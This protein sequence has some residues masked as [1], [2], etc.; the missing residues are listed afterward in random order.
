M[1]T[2]EQL[3]SNASLLDLISGLAAM[4]ESVSSGLNVLVTGIQLDSRLLCKG[5][6]FLAC[7]GRNHDARDYIEEAVNL[8]VA[9]VLAESGGPWQGVSFVNDVPVIAIDNLSAKISEIA[10]RFYS[11]PS[12][13]LVVIGIT[14]TNGK[15]SCSEFIAQVLSEQGYQ[16]GTIG[17]L[18]YGVYG[19]LIETELTTPDAVFTQMALAEMVRDS[20]DPVV[21]E[22]SSVG[23]HQKRV[24]A[25]HFDTAIFTNLSR[26]HLDY[27]ESMEAYAENKKKLFTSKGLKNAI[28][29][30]DDPYALSIINTIA[31]SVEISTYSV[32]NSLATVYAQE[33]NFTRQGFDAVIVTPYGKG[34]V[35][36]KLIGYFN[37]SNLLAV[38]SAL[39]IYQS[40]KGD[41]NITELCAQVSRLKPVNGRMEII[42]D[43]EEITAVVDYAHTPDGLRSALSGL[44]DH[45][46]GKIW[47]IFGCGGNRDKGKRPMMG[48]IAETFADKLIIADDNPRNE[49]GDKIV[50]HIL[51]GISDPSSVEVI[52]DRAEAISYAI[53]N[54]AVGDVV[55]VA[56]KGH[57][58]YQ[59]VG[60]NKLIFSDANQVRLALQA[61]KKS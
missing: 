57:E 22:V 51:S 60:G 46:S 59:D 42:G 34:T 14:G 9:A 2:A 56:G 19:K 4:P 23:L 35:S 20:V 52:R 18:G 61:R 10:S 26:D 33:L 49:E 30:L 17:T 50:Q 55:L 31:K 1:N 29:N 6:L 53:K 12:S 58:T 41:V 27:H 40:R 7:F 8:G 47:C 24:K 45:F 21:M 15:T 44:R 36:G 16:C 13:K 43:H 3:N 28:V 37:F 48:E 38:I 32:K 54:A 39:A 5:D 25:V 11:D